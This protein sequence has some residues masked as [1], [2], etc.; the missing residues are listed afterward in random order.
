MVD[1]QLSERR[2]NTSFSRLKLVLV[3]GSEQISC[4]FRKV[5]QRFCSVFSPPR[6]PFHANRRTQTCTQ[7]GGVGERDPSR[8]QLSAHVSLAHASTSLQ[9]AARNYQTEPHVADVLPSSTASTAVHI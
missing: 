9:L 3:L 5:V 2:V 1:V 8:G 4:V 7:G 6:S